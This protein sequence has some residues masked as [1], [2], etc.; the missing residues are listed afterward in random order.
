MAANA[1]II[2]DVTLDQTNFVNFAGDT[3][4]LTGNFTNTSSTDT[5]EIDALSLQTAPPQTDNDQFTGPYG[6][7]ILAPGQSLIPTYA[8][9]NP[10]PPYAGD[11][12][13]ANVTSSVADYTGKLFVFYDDLTTGATGIR[14]NEVDFAT[15]VPEP[16]SL[17]LLSGC[18]LSGGLFI[19]QRRK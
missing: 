2:G 6:G 14:S 8:S 13:F 10:Y 3:I 18:L 11:V 9:N 12:L 17:S 16:G 7:D 19:K 5:I 1:A 15:N 4:H